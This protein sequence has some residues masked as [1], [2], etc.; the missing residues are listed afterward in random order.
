[1][2]KSGTGNF[3]LYLRKKK[4]YNDAGETSINWVHDES[5]VV[6]DLVNVFM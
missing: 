1:M 2:M 3:T 5:S 6:N 4:T